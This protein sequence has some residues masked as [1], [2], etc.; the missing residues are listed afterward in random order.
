MSS[1]GSSC[2]AGELDGGEYL[3]LQQDRA[4]QVWIQA[5]YSPIL[6]RRASL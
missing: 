2:E 1:S 5:T 3:R 4:A 6:M